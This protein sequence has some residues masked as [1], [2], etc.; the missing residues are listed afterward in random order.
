[1]DNLGFYQHYGVAINSQQLET[2]VA[3]LI[4]RCFASGTSFHFGGE[5]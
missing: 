2:P 4:C 5:T 1:M 3:V